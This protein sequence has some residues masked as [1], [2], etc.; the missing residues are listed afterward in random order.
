MQQL[1]LAVDLFWPLW[2]L[3]ARAGGVGVVPA[4]D[5]LQEQVGAGQVP[6]TACAR[7]RRGVGHSGGRARRAGG[8]GVFPV[9]D[10]LQ[11]RGGAGQ[12]LASS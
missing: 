1:E 5:Q 7:H 8:A 6:A 12:A 4:D 11:E 3:R 10:P 9:D 2:R